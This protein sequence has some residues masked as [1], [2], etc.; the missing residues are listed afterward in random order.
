MPVPP[1]YQRSTD[2]FY[3]FLQDARDAAGLATTNQAYTMTEGVL[4]AFRRRLELTEAILFAGALPPALRA[5]FV[6]D[7]NPG[8]PKRPFEDEARMTEEVK[9]LRSDHNF[10][11][12][13]A[14]HDVATALWRHVNRAAL[15]SVLARLPG[16]AA[17]FWS[18]D[19][20]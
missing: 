17:R 13:S 3:A 10:A 8:E 6:A 20:R 2:D 5:L 4:R 15:E 11:P 18:A 7:W 12:D 14:I 16:P 1:E 9:E 19:E